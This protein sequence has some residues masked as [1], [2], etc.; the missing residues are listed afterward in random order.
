LP[1]EECLLDEL[2]VKVVNDGR[3]HLI[4]EALEM[5]RL[6]LVRGQHRLL[7]G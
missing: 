4:M 3:L 5:V 7:G 1:L 2:L 6:D